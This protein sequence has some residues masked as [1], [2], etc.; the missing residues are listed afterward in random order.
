MS[1]YRFFKN[2]SFR[3]EQAEACI[4]FFKKMAELLGD[5]YEMVGTGKCRRGG[6]FLIE[7]TDKGI[8][9]IAD[10]Y[11]YPFGTESKIT[12]YTKPY[13]SFRISDHWN[14]FAPLKQ[15]KDEKFLQCFNVDLPRLTTR[16]DDDRLNY[17]SAIQ[18]ALFGNHDD[19]AYHC[20]Y[21]AYKDHETH[22]WKWM[23]TTPEE[24]IEKYALI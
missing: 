10:H 20:V 23:E 14:W 9:R 7:G 2:D 16:K 12:Y 8:F 18:V 21:G 4:K 5:D 13:W 19:E 3:R 22:E 17:V 24:I 11:L 1:K 6:H 15:C